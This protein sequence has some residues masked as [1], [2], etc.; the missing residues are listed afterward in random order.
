MS[1]QPQFEPGSTAA[2]EPEAQPV[3]PFWRFL[4][5]TIYCVAANWI[6]VTLAFATLSRHPLIADAAY[7]LLGCVFLVAGFSFMLRIFDLVDE[8]HTHALGLP[9][10]RTAVRQAL[11]GLGIGGLLIFIA[12]AA[13]GI[14]GDLA[15]NVHVSAH[16]LRLGFEVFLLLAFGAMLEELMFRGYP[17]QRLAESIG[18]AGAILVFSALFGAVHLWNPNAGGFLSWGFFNTIAVGVLFAVAYLRTGS[19]WL[20]FGLHFAWNFF[21]GV[22][23]G[24]PVSGLRDFSVIVRTVATGPRILTGAGYGIEASL[25]GAVVILLGFVPVIALTRKQPQRI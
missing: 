13:I 12:V 19:L 4:I 16:T 17:F 2:I 10:N 18:S 7:R 9:L 11:L 25:T 21:L 6:A 15:I 14:F 23:F 22:V 8:D 1:E 20:P 24:L 5:A 3:R